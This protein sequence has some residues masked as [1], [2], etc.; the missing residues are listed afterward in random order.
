MFEFEGTKRKI[1]ESAVEL[2]AAHGYHNVSIRDLATQ[3]GIKSS[4]IYNHFESKEAIL[5]QIYDF[6]D[7]NISKA[8]TP[9]ADLMRYASDLHPHEAMMAV[10]GFYDEEVTDLISDAM[11]IISSMARSDLKADQLINKNVIEL[12]QYN[13]G[14]L[15]EK[16]I[17]TGKIKPLDIK[18]FVSIYSHYCYGRAVRFYTEQVRDKEVFTANLRMLFQLVE[19][20]PD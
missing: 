16:L 6:F 12:P 15:L 9:L 2:F 5:Y 1:F 11:S 13:M 8:R 19:V 18:N 4:S 3:V 10:V 20:V 7:Y 17:E 14:K